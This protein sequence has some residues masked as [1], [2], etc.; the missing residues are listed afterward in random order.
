ML[1][2]DMVPATGRG[3]TAPCLCGGLTAAAAQVK[4][5]QAALL[6]PAGSWS[7]QGPGPG[8]V[9]VQAAASPSGPGGWRHKGE[10][11]S[12]P[13]L[14]PD[15]TETAAGPRWTTRVDVVLL[16]EDPGS[17]ALRLVGV[18]RDLLQALQHLRRWRSRAT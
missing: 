13:Q 3:H 10:D 14:P 4:H 8:R 11:K 9:L 15:P 16:Q 1:G 12:A 18:F 2:V 6:G 17:R 7:R 5:I